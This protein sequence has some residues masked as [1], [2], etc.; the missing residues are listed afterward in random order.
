MGL[1]KA[2]TA[3]AAVAVISMLLLPTAALAD[4]ANVGSSILR[5]QA[6]NT[7]RALTGQVR[8]RKASLYWTVSNSNVRAEPTTKSHRLGTLKAG[9]KVAVLDVVPDRD[10]YQI[11]YNGQAAYVWGPLLKKSQD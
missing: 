6:T 10:W 4:G 3:V 7:T 9:S 1:N 2:P 11:D 5:N 8:E